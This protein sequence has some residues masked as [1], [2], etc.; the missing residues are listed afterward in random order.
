MIASAPPST[1]ARGLIEEVPVVVVPAE[2]N[3]GGDRHLLHAAFHRLDDP[4]DSPGLPA[5]RRAQAF[6]REVIDRAA[7]VDV[8]QIG[9]ARFDQTGR[10]PHLLG[11]GAG[12]LHAEE[13]LVGGPPDQRELAPPALLQPPRHGHLAHRDARA[14]FDAQPPIGQVRALGHRRHHEGA[15]ERSASD[16]A[17]I[18]SALRRERSGSRAT[19]A[20]WAAEPL[21]P[22]ASLAVTLLRGAACRPTAAAGASRTAAVDATPSAPASGMAGV[23]RAAHRGVPGRLG[24]RAHQGRVSAARRCSTRSFDAVVARWSRRW[25]SAPRVTSRR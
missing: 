21:L 25:T 2:A 1:A 24:A 19:L 10:P 9:A 13:R 7:E 22:P 15:G 14:Q 4:P 3:L 11:V 6:A 18:V 12:Q 20:A 17:P 23:E 8:D 16:I 5:D